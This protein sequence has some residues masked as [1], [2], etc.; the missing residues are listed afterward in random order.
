MKKQTALLN[1]YDVII[2]GAGASG[3]FCSGTFPHKVK[4][5]ILEKTKKAGTKLL[6]S[7]SGQCNITHAGSIKEFPQHYGKNGN[8]VRSSL[9]K[10]NNSHLLQFLK[11]GGIQTIAREDGK[12]FPASMDAHDV[13]NFL[14][15]KTKENGFEISYESPVV[16]I[17]K[18]NPG[19][20]QVTTTNQVYLSKRLIIA[21]GGCSYPTTGSD[22]SLFPILR[23]D[24]GVRI[25]P[26]R[27]AL[28]P[29]NVAEYPYGN[30]AGISFSSV[31]I[32][33]F[34]KG[35]KV[36]EGI[37]DLLLTHSNLSGPAIINLSKYI[38]QEDCLR[39]NYLYPQSYQQA[40]DH[41]K[42]VAKNNCG[43]LSNLLAQQFNLPK[44]FT[45]SLVNRYGNSLKNLAAM[46]TGEEFI[47]RSVG[48]F[49]TAMATT[50][51]ISLDELN[52]T[53]MELT[54]H[55]TLFAIGEAIDIDGDTGGYN[56]QF[57]YSS[58][59]CVSVTNRF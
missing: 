1:E 38:L 8:K 34:R 18:R 35:K 53:T 40:L 47:V 41:L 3:L 55:S 49:N 13:L 54:N 57:A 28:S 11:S 56:L 16:K 33:I 12:V 25:T 37:G 52:L 23:R 26:L 24:L 45:K 42:S 4:G 48:G 36:T 31:E 32:D 5:L 7:G 30:L 46:L 29:V 59:N 17:K 19:S 22:G 50:G 2:I 15:K 44:R 21:S 51:G 10:Y 58:A 27:P 14:L 39:I 9:Y 43:N 20:W 6:M